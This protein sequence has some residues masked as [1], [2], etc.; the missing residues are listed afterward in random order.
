VIV[1]TTTLREWNGWVI[2][3]ILATTRVL[4]KFL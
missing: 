1:A 3:F 4:G 2:R